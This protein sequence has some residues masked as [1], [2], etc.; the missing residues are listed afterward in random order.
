MLVLEQVARV[1]RGWVN[2][3]AVSDSRPRIRDFIRAVR[4]YSYRWF[5]RR[6]GNRYIPWKSI[7][8]IL[9]RVGFVENIRLKSIQ[10]RQTKDNSGVSGA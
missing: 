7:E 8:A 1:V 4:R 10:T 2:F 6:G 5:Y 9:C 3:F